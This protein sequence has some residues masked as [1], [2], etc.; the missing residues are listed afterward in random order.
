MAANED[1]RRHGRLAQAFEGSWRG[2]SGQTRCRI[3]DFSPGG[4]FVQS[5]AMPGTGEETII[6]IAFGDR[7][8]TFKG[9]VVYV[10]AG[11]GF[12]VR[13]EDLSPTG[14]SQLQELMAAAAE[15][16]WSDAG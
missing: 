3:G 7:T 14:I 4:C 9:T 6:S 10:E 5:L 1:R 15:K 12:A 8:L 11:M 16:G 2:A 13:F